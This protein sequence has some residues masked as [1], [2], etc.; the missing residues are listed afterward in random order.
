MRRS[1]RKR[2]LSP[3]HRDEPVV[4]PLPVI[5]PNPTVPSESPKQDQ[6]GKGPPAVA[7][8]NLCKKMFRDLRADPEIADKIIECLGLGISPEVDPTGEICAACIERIDRQHAFR[9]RALHC[10]SY[11]ESGLEE[12]EDE[13][14]CRFCLKVNKQKLVELFPGGAVADEVGK[15]RDCLA[16]EI[17]SWDAVTKLCDECIKG[18]EELTEFRAEFSPTALPVKLEEVADS[19]DSYS[20]RSEN[21]YDEEDLDYTLESD[22]SAVDEEE[23]PEIQEKQQSK[24]TSARSLPWI[25]TDHMDRNFDV[26]DETDESLEVVYDEYP[27]E[28]RSILSDGSSLWACVQHKL[29]GCQVKLKIDA[30]GI[31]ASG[32]GSSSKHTHLNELDKLMECPEGKGLVTFEGKEQPF[33]LLY[34][35]RDRSQYTRS[36]ILDG[37]KYF[38]QQIRFKGLTGIWNCQNCFRQCSAVL[39]IDALFE[40]FEMRGRHNHPPLAQWEIDH[41]L[42]LRGINDASLEAFRTFQRTTSRAAIQERA[43][44][45]ENLTRQVRTGNFQGVKKVQPTARAKPKRNDQSPDIYKVLQ[46]GDPERNFEVVQVES[47]YKVIDENR[48]EYCYF[49]RL[50]DN[51]TLWKCTMTQLRYCKAIA[52]ISVGGKRLILIERKHNHET[53][54]LEL[55]NYP[56]GKRIIAEEPVWL[57]KYFSPYHESRRVLYRGFL[58]ILYDIAKHGIIRWKCVKKQTCPA[59]MLSEGDFRKIQIKEEHSHEELTQSSIDSMLTSNG[60]PK[61]RKVV[62]PIVTDQPDIEAGDPMQILTT[63][64]RN[65]PDRN[66]IVKQIGNKLMVSWGGRDFRFKSMQ[67]DGSS[68]WCCVW[69]DI[70]RCP[71]KLLI[72]ANGKVASMHETDQKHNHHDEDIPVF[73]IPDG[74]MVIYDENTQRNLSCFL[75]TYNAEF[76]DNRGIIYQG[77]KYT[78]CRIDSKGY[79]TWKCHRTC[80]GYIKV[81]S[82]LRSILCKNSHQ[83]TAL[84]LEEINSI[85]GSNQPDNS[86]LLEAS[87]FT[88]IDTPST[89]LIPPKKGLLTASDLLEILSTSDPDRN[90]KV[91]IHKKNMKIIQN[92]FEYYY[93]ISTAQ[94]SSWKCVYTTIRACRAS[95]QLDNT[96]KTATLPEIPRHSHSTKPWTLLSFPQGRNTIID[97]QTNIAKPFW[98]RVQPNFLRPIISFLYEGHRYRLVFLNESGSSSTWGCSSSRRCNVRIFVDGLFKRVRNGNS[99]HAEPALCPSDQA[100]WI[101]QTEAYGGSEEQDL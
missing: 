65:D 58:Y 24:T 36:L 87:T 95:I 12:S 37:F 20:I 32:V 76:F 8:C 88:L 62:E 97:A 84:T 1:L 6:E 67:S 25:K 92:D 44:K 4:A 64:G 7:S 35:Q 59:V 94:Y 47:S 98:F 30:K 28:F 54:P 38:L 19:S 63:I 99:I 100:A 93:N 69:N 2:K 101:E 45:E 72:S 33:W 75:F 26:L 81:E 31:L 21:D 22:H 80:T 57:L 17:N 29:R 10:N 16:I 46:R 61:P 39:R 74:K 79:S 27:F 78:L 91:Q 34:G 73:C 53:R 85:T 89:S 3:D 23:E 70:R 52:Q 55:L 60:T 18:I 41:A 49:A 56:L 14:V 83:H 15:I 96:C 48:Y 71:V 66:F 5:I 77:R 51:S 11:V 50:E 9:R 86:D 82:N 43:E 68:A 13:N 90:F 40:E 42:R